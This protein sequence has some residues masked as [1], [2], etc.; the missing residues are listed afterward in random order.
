MILLTDNSYS[1]DEFLNMEAKILKTL[2]YK[3]NYNAP[4]LYIRRL[5]ETIDDDVAKYIAYYL[6]EEFTISEESIKY[7]P[8]IIAAT[9]F[10][11]AVKITQ[12]SNWTDA[13]VYYSGGYTVNQLMEC[14]I[15]ILMF[16]KVNTRHRNVY[17]KYAS[18]NNY[19]ASKLTE[20]WLKQHSMA[21]LLSIS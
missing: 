7:V 18:A 5:A 2:Q 9:S 6:S 15:D 4:S 8:S 11:I 16:V 19:R 20:E 13:M 10:F 17:I 21:D 14:I 1:R 12:N 3:V